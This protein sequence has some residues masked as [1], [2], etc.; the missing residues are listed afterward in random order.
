[1]AC[2]KT[3]IVYP[4]WDQLNRTFFTTH[5]NQQYRD[6]QATFTL[7]NLSVVRSERTKSQ[8]SDNKKQISLSSHWLALPCLFRPQ[9]TLI[10]P[11]PASSSAELTSV[12]FQWLQKPI[13]S[14]LTVQTGVALQNVREESDLRP[15]ANV[16]WIQF[17]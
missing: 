6:I 9:H 13:K 17:K 16:T 4:F 3:V 12:A 14:D 15:N 8:P 7:Q 2:E 11:G 1:M 5:Q 10:L